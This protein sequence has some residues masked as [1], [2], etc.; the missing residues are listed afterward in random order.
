MIENWHRDKPRYVCKRFRLLEFLVKRGFYPDK[1]L[2][3]YNNPR[4]NVWIFENSPELA[5]AVDE[6]LIQ[7]ENRDK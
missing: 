5:D 6:F 7:Q 3:D 4:Y 1:T 2:P